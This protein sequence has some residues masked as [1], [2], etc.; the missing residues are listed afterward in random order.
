MNIKNIKIRQIKE[1]DRE[2]WTKLFKNYA[3][4]Y[5]VKITDEIINNVW[6]WVHS[7]EHELE[8]IVAELESE[9]IAFAHYRRMPSPLRG[10][11]IGFLDDLYVSVDYRGNK[12]AKKLILKLKEISA[13]KNWNLIRWIT[14]DN[15]FRAKKVYDEIS[16]LSNW[17]VYELD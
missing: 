16:T 13:E 6:N 9:I 3:E 7:K 17:D 1:K 12:I 14:R 8:A 10:K 2:N 5:E 15:N 11:D 4:F